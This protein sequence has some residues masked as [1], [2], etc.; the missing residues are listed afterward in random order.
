[1]SL[2]SLDRFGDVPEVVE[3]GPTLEENALK[4]ARTVRDATGMSRRSPTTRASRWTLLRRR[5]GCLS[6]RGTP[7]TE[8]GYEANNRKLLDALEGVPDGERTARFRCVMALALS[9]E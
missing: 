9:A 7:A 8:A 6:R 3:D 2:V 1:M 4:K 5:A